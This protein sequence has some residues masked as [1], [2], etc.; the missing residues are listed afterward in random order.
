MELALGGREVTVT[1]SERLR[2]QAYG[3]WEGMSFSSIRNADPELYAAMV[4][5]YTSFTP[6][7]GE[8]F[9]AVEA[10]S[11]GLAAEMMRRHPVGDL[12]IVGHGAALRTLVTCMTGL[13][14]EA[15]WRFKVDSCSLTV[16]DVGVSPAVVMLL[17]D[18]SHIDGSL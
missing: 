18:T 15:G 9:R 6:P 4:E 12:L 11:Q 5:D 10:R 7:G 13:P 2:E 1:H 14:L 17:N 8:N 16:L 3:R